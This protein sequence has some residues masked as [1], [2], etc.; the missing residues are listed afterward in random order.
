[1]ISPSSR[2]QFRLP[3]DGRMENP[4][5][6]L[7]IALELHRSG[8][9]QQAES[10][11]RDILQQQPDCVDAIYLLGALMVQSDRADEAIEL[12]KTGVSKFPNHAPILVNLGTAY[13]RRNDLPNAEI[14]YRRAL[15]IDPQSFDATKNLA[16]N[17]LKQKKA[18]N[19]IALLNRAL[20]IDP[21][22]IEARLSLAMTLSKSS[23]HEESKQHF[24]TILEST[25]DHRI[26]LTGYGQA[27][28]KEEVPSEESLCVWKRIVE[29]HPNHAGMLNNYATVLKNSKQYANAEDA[30]RAALAL[31][32]DFFS[33]WCNLAI[34]LAAQNRFEE[35]CSAFEETLRI[36]GLR[37]ELNP[38][39][40]AFAQI[41]EETWKEFGCIAA[42]QLAA[43]RNFIGDAPRAFEA[44]DTA[45]SIKPE[46]TDSLMMKGFLYLQS[47]QF[48]EGWPLY[49]KR[50]QSK[51]KPRSFPKPEWDGSSLVGKRLL[52]HAEQGLGDSLQFI[53]YAKL[54][55]EQG[56][57]VHFL[58]HRS[59]VP[60][61]RLCPYLASVIADGDPLPEFDLHLPLMSLPHV[62]RTTFDTVPKSVPYIQAAPELINDWYEKLRAYEGFRIGIAWQG[63]PNFANDEVRRVPLKLFKTIASVPGVRLVCLQQREG[64]DQLADVDFELI[65]FEN[66]D[67][68]SGAFM[69]TAAIIQNLDLV[70]SPCTAIPHLT[71]ALGRPVWLAKSFAA[72]WRWMNDHREENPWY[73][74]MTMFRQPKLW[75]WDSVFLRMRERLV[76]H[77]ESKGTS[78]LLFPR[79]FSPPNAATL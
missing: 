68:T 55:R 46:D 17:Q 69:D 14:F 33:V 22:S 73:P 9:V 21:S 36:G 58:S 62:F 71:G 28:L 34:I 45:L 38:N 5:D 7:Q 60:L 72:E 8:A 57:S 18:D 13:A 79:G 4:T 59:L 30:C 70:I 61:L 50:K 27:L 51:H 23:R 19:A 53:R 41:S 44:V 15:A 29:L 16:T 10:I 56:A 66:L 24:R 31:L 20:E 64:M 75:D 39:L 2:T 76:Q 11:Y 43:C 65:R 54:A 12:L 77:L 48:D 3:L 67:A 32:P 74:S 25:P 63:N 52:I 37:S 1:M 78:N 35:S 26:A 40:P 47:G 49:E 6:R 42:C